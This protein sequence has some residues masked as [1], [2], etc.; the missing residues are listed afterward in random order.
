[1]FVDSDLLNWYDQHGRSLPWRVKHGRPD[2]YRVWL[3]EIM[4]QQTTVAAVKPYF[5]H[6]ISRWPDVI[7][8]AAAN[9]A[10]VMAAWAGLGY[11]ARARNL[12]ACAQAIVAR[13]DVFPET[14][15]ELLRLPG[16]GPYTAAAIAAIAFDQPA[17]AL[18]ANIIRV[19]SRVLSFTE[20][21]P[22]GRDRLAQAWQPHVARKR[23]GD[24]T[25]AAMDLGAMICTVKAPRCTS[26]PIASHCAAFMAGNPEDYPVKPAKVARPERSGTAWWLEAEAHVLLLTRPATG[27]LGGMR[28]LP[29]DAWDGQ[30]GLFDPADFSGE[31]HAAGSIVHVFTHFRLT[32]NILVQRLSQRPAIDPAIGQ[33]WP[34]VQLDQAGLPSVFAKAAG[35][36]MASK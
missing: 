33:W 4:L 5:A 2:P 26:C 8:L 23:P 19:A 29:S 24:F 34:L 18:D 6:F 14:V 9:P 35:R 22:T 31:W 21:L 1:M 17:V 12:I 36:A 16:I 25:Q 10:E 13:G 3:S 27:L 28:A 30:G 32:L 7:A 11:Y 20:L 15:A